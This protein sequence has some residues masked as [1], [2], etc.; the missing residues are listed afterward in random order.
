M[1]KTRGLPP[2]GTSVAG[3]SVSGAVRML[4][5]AVC[6]CT[7]M[8]LPAIEVMFAIV[9]FF[10]CGGRHEIA[11]C[12]VPH[13]ANAAD[14]C[15]SLH[16]H[17]RA[18]ACTRV[19]QAMLMGNLPGASAATDLLKPPLT[20]FPGSPGPHKHQSTRT[21]KPA[22]IVKFIERE[23]Q[24]RGCGPKPSIVRLGIYREVCTCSSVGLC[25]SKDSV[26]DFSLRFFISGSPITIYLQGT[27]HLRMYH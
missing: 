15:L 1:P 9:L 6:A 19:H 4:E 7:C 27:A 11:A 13:T 10:W 5:T 3:N 12:R 2:L 16:A 21:P 20:S 23:L 26:S 8:C 17:T 25:F 22:A 18:R 24:N 14:T